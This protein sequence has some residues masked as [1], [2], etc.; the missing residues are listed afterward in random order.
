MKDVKTKKNSDVHPF[1]ASTQI[2]LSVYSHRHGAYHQNGKLN[3]KKKK[4]K[5]T[6]YQNESCLSYLYNLL[7]YSHFPPLA[8]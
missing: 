2:A 6:L 5:R 3:W 4:M 7:T 1:D 8:V